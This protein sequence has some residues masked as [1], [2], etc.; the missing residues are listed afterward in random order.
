MGGARHTISAK[1]DINQRN[2]VSDVTKYLAACEEFME[3]VT[4]AHVISAIHADQR[5]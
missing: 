2:A 3:L 1:E 4:V 5:S